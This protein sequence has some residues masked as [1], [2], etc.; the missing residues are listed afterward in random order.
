MKQLLII[1]LVFI[2]EIVQGKYCTNY[3][4]LPDNLQTHYTEEQCYEAVKLQ[5]DA[6]GC[7]GETFQYNEV[8]GDC[9]CATDDC[10]LQTASPDWKI[11]RQNQ[12]THEYVCDCAA[13]FEGNVCEID[14][15]EC[16]LD[17]CENGAACTESATDNSV[18]LG[19]YH[20]ECHLGWEG[21]DCKIMDDICDPPPCQ[22]GATCSQIL[23][24]NDASLNYYQCECLAGFEGKDCQI[25]IDECVVEPCNYGGVCTETTDG[26]TEAPGVFHCACSTYFGYTGLVCDECGPGKGRDREGR[27]TEC[28]EPQ[29]NNV[30]T[31]TAPCADQECPEGFGVSSD[32]WDI[33][34]GNC[35]ECPAGEESMAGTGVCT[36]IDYCE[37]SP[38][39]NDGACLPLPSSYMCACPPGFTGLNCEED[40]NECASV[41]CQNGAVCSETSDGITLTPAVYHCECPAGYSGTNCEEDINECNPD[42]C[43][44]SGVCTES[45]T[46]AAVLLGEYNCACPAGYT[47]DSCEIDT[48]ECEPDPCQ[49]S[50]VC[51]ESGTD[52][53]VLLGEYNCACPAGY[54][55]DSCEIDTNECHPDL[56]QNGAV[57]TETSDG[58]TLTPGVHH[59]ECPAGYSGVNC[60]IDTNECDPDP[61]QNGA[62]CAEGDIDEYSCTC[63]VGFQG[64]N[65]EIDIDECIVEPCFFDAI[66]KDSSTDVLILPGEFECVCVESFGYS[67]TLC[68]ECGPGKG[69]DDDGSC[70][71]CEQPQINNVPTKTA[72]CADQE[73]PTG[74][75]V[76]SNN[77]V[78][79]GDNCEECPFGEGSMAGSGVCSD[80]NECDPD[81]CQNSGVC[82]ESGTDAAVLLGEYNCECPTGYT[83]SMCEIDTNECDQDHCQN[84]AICTETVSGL[85]PTAGEYHCEC[86]IGFTGTD[87]E[88]DTN[89]CDPDP[90][91]N[92]GVCAEGEL[93]EYSCDCA[94]GYNGKNCE[95]DIDECVLNPCKNE[96]FCKDSNTDSSIAPADFFCECVDYFGYTGP[97][98]NSCGPGKGRDSDGR[99]RPCEH[100]QW[101]NVS[102]S[103]APCSDQACGDGY[104]VTS[105]S[106][107]TIGIVHKNCEEC[108]AGTGSPAGSGVCV[109]SNECSP[110]PCQN[111]AV[112]T[113]SGTDAAVL[114]GE[115]HCECADGFTGTN[116]ETPKPCTIDPCQNGGACLTVS[117]NSYMCACPPGY[118]GMHCQEDTNECDP[119]PCQNNG[120]CTESGTD[121]TVLPGEYNCEC[122][123]GWEGSICEDMMDLCSPDPC[124]NGAACSQILDIND[125]AL[126]YYSCACEIGYNGVNCEIDIDECIVEPCHFSAACKDSNTDSSIAPGDFS[127]DCVLDFGY[128]GPLCNEC[129][130]GSGRDDDGKCRPC[131]QPQINNVTS[132]SAVCADQE[133]PDNFGVSSDNWG[134][135][136]SICEQCPFG[137]E[138]PLGSGVCVD[139][140]ECDPDPC[141]NSGV[142][143]ETSD[144]MTP[145]VGVYFCLCQIGYAGVDCEEDINECDT[146][147]CQNGAT[148]SETSDG[149][150]LMPGVY[151]CECPDGYN[152]TNCD[153][154]I[155]QC[156]PDPCQN[157][158]VCT[159]LGAGEYSCE[160]GVG[161]QGDNCEIDI[162][163]CIVN[164]CHFEALCKESSTST[165]DSIAPGEFFCDCIESFGYTG[166]L[167]N[168]CQA[169][170]GRDVDG[171]CRPCEQPQINNVTTKTAPCADQVC[172]E[173]FGVTSDNW[174]TVGGNCEACIAGEF[175]PAG[176]G[177]CV[178]LNECSDP[179]PCQNSAVCTESTTSA[180]IPLGEYQ[181]TCGA[182]YSGK[183]CEIDDKC[184]PSPCAPQTSQYCVEVFNMILGGAEYYCKCSPGWAGQNCT[185]LIDK[186][187]YEPCQNGA[188]SSVIHPSNAALN[189]YNCECDVG[190]TG[191]NCDIDVNECDPDPCQNGAVCTETTDGITPEVGVYHCACDAGYNGTKCE[192][193]L[194]RCLLEE[195]CQNG[196]TCIDGEIGEYSCACAVGYE[197]IDCE[198]DVNE[199][200]L[201]PCQHGGICTETIDGVT[202]APGVFHCACSDYFGYTGRLCEECQAGH[203]R[204][205]DGRCTECEQP[206]INNVTTKTAPCADQECPEGFGVVSDN[207]SWNILGANCEACE[208]GS[209]S[210]AGS[211]VCIDTNEC[212]PDPCQNGA[213]CSQTSD[214]VT[215]LPTFYFCAC[216][217]G[218][219]GTNCE[220]DINE[221]DPD[222]CQNGAKCTEGIG[223]YNCECANGFTGTKCEEDI[224]ECDPDPCQNSGICSESGTNTS[225]LSGEYHCECAAGFTGENC[226]EPINNCDP[227]PCKNSGVCL[228]LPSGYQC[229]CS[230]GYSGT[231]CEID[232]NECDP[233]PCL[234]SATCTETSDGITPGVGVYHCECVAGFAGT[235]CDEYVGICS[236]EPCQNGG[237]CLP[238]IALG[239]YTCDCLDGFE[240]LQCEVDV[241]ECLLNP[242]LHGG[243][244]TETSDGITPTPGVF[245][246]ACSDYWGYDGKTCSECGP[247]KGRDNWNRC[248]PCEN[249]LINNETT[250][251]T[252]CVDQ[253]CPE[254]Y[255]VVSEAWNGIVSVCQLCPFGEGSPAAV[256]GVCQNINECDPDPC[257]NSGICSETSDGI[258]PIVGEFFCLCQIGYEGTNCEEDINECDPDPCQNSG[259][260]TE[261]SDGITPTAGV[262][263]CECA[264]GYS[265]V[266]CQIPEPCDPD[267]CQNGGACLTADD[268]YMCACPPGYSGTNCEEDINECDPDP[269]LNSGVCTETSDGTIQAVG[270][271][272]CTC[273]PGHSGT[274]CETPEPCDPD[275][276][277]NNATCSVAGTDFYFCACQIGYYGVDCQIP[278][279]NECDPDPCQNGATCTANAVGYTC[280]CSVGY[281]GTNCDHDIHECDPN[282]CQN[283]ATCTETS[284]GITLTPGVY[285][286]ECVNDYTGTNCQIDHNHND[287]DS[288]PCQNGGACLTVDDSYT[289]ACPPEYSGTNCENDINECEANV[290]ICQGRVCRNTVGSYECDECEIGYHSGG[291]VE[292]YQNECTCKNGIVSSTCLID[293]T[294]TCQSCGVGFELVGKKCV[295][296]SS[297]ELEEEGEWDWVLFVVVALGIVVLFAVIWPYFSGSNKAAVVL[298][299]AKDDEEEET[300]PLMSKNLELIF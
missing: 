33:L 215:E 206:Q 211:G 187:G 247:G 177:V 208:L 17:P 144:G 272:H 231:N 125:A 107:S 27:C 143:S 35:A 117:D 111:G 254:G 285:H 123:K 138:S 31:K 227:D 115:Y 145:N 209:E 28:A 258:T 179:D 64:E 251:N 261:T 131:E 162:D 54:T 235:K 9:G 190:F 127:C 221:C 218:W 148:C 118:S 151:H 49:N 274:N 174:E 199:C 98:C 82:T 62:S 114:L 132:H 238:E 213:V 42:L 284:D 150:T 282:P 96:A 23:D 204:A 298:V 230:P 226:E 60:E 44:N 141:Q 202:E 63:R 265:G 283:G 69:R 243:I 276:C 299:A 149:I 1:L 18:A 249:P 2:I 14:T 207:L 203:G 38:C 39:Q 56:C 169:G 85:T 154:V 193:Y 176:S 140:N 173:G 100:P 89:E 246:C 102:T 133:C 119:D 214:G 91:Q 268:S 25:D 188:C 245:H 21:Q 108:I 217:T 55:G 236:T 110:D 109:D 262:Y 279:T 201:E 37:N 142:C 242:C 183:N 121:D 65:C 34:G 185:D 61:C 253:A 70:K 170:S 219:E 68:N 275:P 106:W 4:N 288:N 58:V 250:A 75:G 293:G 240:G 294:E 233:N 32:N 45:G 286:C 172:G 16:D 234:N 212:D 50:G 191:T 223:E 139:T 90:C 116:C 220:E 130:P 222:P 147:P 292:C 198:K 237:N 20:C 256:S 290:D 77:W 112:C 19:D 157:E 277:Q 192:E 48:N 101:N 260:C 11:M 166:P 26:T 257:Q 79:I 270:V 6:L 83:G 167:C 105:D 269:C 186:C 52:A 40:I 197:G 66:C 74:F 168:E 3:V 124:Q 87:C 81:P 255:G 155:N 163:E 57:C 5:L 152:G 205:D 244:C 153:E 78:T 161:F 51:T 225:V 194:G 12:L 289:C 210:G 252:V 273:P 136:V 30:V 271:Y 129:Q 232:T 189:S 95:I 264:T 15:N 263:H 93:G 146:D 47:G 281:E 224:N 180:A 97:L 280:S 297:R 266:N 137:E 46:D 84:G 158:G 239:E 128:T 7:T 171:K 241:N 216:P 24:I 94:T 228:S 59:C 200:L 175:S 104:G 196:A 67:G 43:Q 8:A 92:E 164:P 184:N 88:I 99:C 160:C 36:A 72:P 134:G 195:P 135:I 278:I 120:V 53:A 80:T 156:D 248:R 13:G 73:C 229:T 76:T 165:D 267:P 159:Q 122:T 41:P 296:E 86:Q 103:T 300:Q 287:C 291:D 182:G 10:T 178:D 22:N 181:C 71:E 29:I 126:N 259:V 295:Q 113:E